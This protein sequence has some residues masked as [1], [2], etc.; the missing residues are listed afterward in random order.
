MVVLPGL[1]S[2]QTPRP[3]C[4]PGDTAAS[5][6]STRARRCAQMLPGVST[7]ARS[8]EQDM[9]ENRTSVGTIV[10]GATAISAVPSVGEPDVLRVVQLLPGVEARN[11]FNNGLNVR[12]GEADHNLILLDG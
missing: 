11:D 7:T 5:A 1:L 10:L 3:R 2:S 12:G 8:I 9:F 6:D 4:I